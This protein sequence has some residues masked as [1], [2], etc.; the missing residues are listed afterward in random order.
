M[1]GLCLQHS[2]AQFQFHQE[3]WSRGDSWKPSS[4]SRPSSAVQ[5]AILRK[6]G[7]PKAQAGDG[8]LP[9]PKYRD[10]TNRTT[11]ESQKVVSRGGLEGMP[12][13]RLALEMLKRIPGLVG[14]YSLKEKGM[15]KLIENAMEH[16]H[17][18]HS[19]FQQLADAINSVG[20]GVISM[21]AGDRMRVDRNTITFLVLAVDAK[22]KGAHR[23]VC[24]MGL[25]IILSKNI[26]F[27]PP[28]PRP[29]YFEQQHFPV[30]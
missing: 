26:H 13:E 21:S 30:L 22:N 6:V 20:R 25:L 3:S 7:V 23:Q 4:T 5:E 17:A 10:Q 15:Q 8:T 14:F 12:F 18:E 27:V 2:P 24:A 9:A 29:S 19:F 1:F 11:R 28:P 16:P